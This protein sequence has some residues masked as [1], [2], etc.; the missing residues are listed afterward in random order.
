MIGMINRSA[1]RFGLGLL[2]S[3]MMAGA[4]WA[5]IVVQAPAGPV[6]GRAEHGVT[7]FKGLPY[8]Q[9]PVGDLRWRAPQPLSPWSQV[10]DAGEFGA[11]CPQPASRPGS[12]YSSTLPKVDEDCLFLNIWA[13]QKAEGAPVMVWIHGGSLVTGAGSEGMYDGAALAARGIVVVTINYRLGVLGY[14]AHPGLSAESPDRVSGNYGLLDQIRALEWVR[15]NIAA[16][17]GDPSKVTVAGESAGALSVMYLMASPAARGLFDKAVAQSA[18]MI[19]TPELRS[20]SH[21]EVSAEDAGKHLADQLGRDLAGMRAMDAME[22][23]TAAATGGFAPFGN[24]DGKILPRQLVETFDRGE[25]AQTPLL[26]G[27]NDGEIR[28][29]RFLAPPPPASRTAYEAAIRARYGDLTSEFLRQH[30]SS[31]M[32]ESVQ[33]AVRDMLYGWTAERLAVKQ[34]QAGQPAYLYHFD[35]PYRAT[36]D[37]RLHAFHAAEIPFVFGTFDR[38]SP[39]WPRPALTA[40][41]GRFADAMA[42]YWASFIRTGTPHA[43]GQA[44]WLPYGSDQNYMALEATP[45]AGRDPAPGM[46]EL[47]EEIVCRR[48]KAGGVPWNWNVGLWAPEGMPRKC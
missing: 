33:T 38:S 24:V 30:P 23:V 17:G 36:T 1:R 32:A 37:Q 9:A 18:Y 46:Y 35:H 3:A 28:S 11:A 10:R 19:S 21:G 42:D 15:D 29:L 4:A 47:N 13:P 14:M 40:A 31:D 45:R 6:D 7:V 25:Q 12:I 20:S 41:H 8:A 39:L 44:A 34:T 2:C 26:V 16:F 5:D 43:E 48:M 27:Y 22:L